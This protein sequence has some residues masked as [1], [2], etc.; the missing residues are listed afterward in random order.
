M[1]KIV[2][3]MKARLG[4]DKTKYDK[5]LK[6]AQTNAN[7]FG[8]AM[9]KLGGI[10]AGAFAITKI[11]Q[12]GKQFVTLFDVQAKAEQSLLVAL[13]G[14]RDIQQ[15]LIKQSQELQKT[16]LFG[17]EES[18]KAAGL[19]AM[20]LGDD[21]KAISKLLP[22]VQD[23]ATAKF[24][25]NLA[26]AADMVAKSVGSSTNALSR[27][28]IT[29]EGA[30]GSSERLES[31]INGMNKQVG[32]QSAAAALVGTGALVQLSNIWGDFQ[33]FLGSALMPALNK[34]AEWGKDFISNLGPK[35]SETLRK[36]Q[37]EV[38]VLVG[39]ITGENTSR[40]VRK[41]LIS[42]LQTKYPD[43]LKN[44][45]IEKT[46][47]KELSDRLKDVNEEYEKRIKLAV[48]QEL[49]NR[50][51]KDFADSIEKEV[52]L[53]KTL[54]KGRAMLAEESSEWNKDQLAA[55]R[56]QMEYTERQIKKEQDYRQGLND[57]IKDSI[58]LL[59]EYKD[60]VEAV[61]GGGGGA[62]GAGGGGTAGI[63]RIMGPGEVSLPSISA[64]GSGITTDLKTL[65]PSLIEANLQF[66]QLLQNMTALE[67]KE[68]RIGKI[69]TDVFS[70][71]ANV[72]SQSFMATGNVLKNFGKFF[73]DFI[74]G[75]IVKLVAAAIAALALAV[76]IS[77]IPGLNV[78]MG[79]KMAK[80]VSFADKF[81]AGFGLMTGMASGGVIPGGYA[82][83]TFPAMLS[84]GER[85]LTPAQNKN[86][87]SGGFHFTFDE[88]GIRND[89]LYF[90]VKEAERKRNNSF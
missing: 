77:L 78:G 86:Y 75:M 20:L 76:V 3:D 65:A 62:G 28:G 42:E 14:R 11:V 17:D 44:L 39:A 50:Q 7:K 13:K 69:T 38:N 47:N 41:R 30:V 6:G 55:L 80:A 48:Q 25:G 71:F 89:T 12:W 79:A 81:K 83:D 68:A 82:G 84:S 85:V 21:E 31:A 10:L 18:I 52:K 34:V 56:G 2:G 53:T 43:F 87:E 9:K 73:I 63:K 22:L 46:T 16:T 32:G 26:T 29:I 70:G 4:L 40:E 24:G 19:L 27:Y 74:K 8:S 54:S 45:D 64:L 5:G 67:E 51:A 59:G 37:A 33:E 36:E 23:L 58:A 66:Q 88:L 1:A 90:A 61:G 49:V 35:Q 60:A 72:I 57:K 15:R